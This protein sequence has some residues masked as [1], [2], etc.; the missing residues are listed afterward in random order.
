[1]PIEF[2]AAAYRFGH[3]MVRPSYALNAVVGTDQPPAATVK[4]KPIFDAQPAAGLHDLRGFRSIP[5]Q[6]GIDWGYFFKFGDGKHGKSPNKQQGTGTLQPAY[7]IDT[8]AGRSRRA[9]LNPAR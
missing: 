5:A 6:W 8:F 7:R 3:S 9:R 1:M 2:A 4:R